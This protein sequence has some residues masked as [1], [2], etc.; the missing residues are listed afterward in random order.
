MNLRKNEIKLQFLGTQ[1]IN[2]CPF[3]TSRAFQNGFL[4]FLQ[5]YILHLECCSA[6][7]A[8][9]DGSHDVDMQLVVKYS[10]EVLDVLISK[11]PL[12]EVKDYW[13]GVMTAAPLAESKLKFAFE[14]PCGSQAA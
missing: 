6:P 12:E 4:D 1:V 2:D 9:S 3:N 10:F 14:C 8:N 11:Q 13:L 7:F 5:T